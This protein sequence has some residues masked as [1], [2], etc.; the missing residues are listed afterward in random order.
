MRKSTEGHGYLS[1]RRLLAAMAAIAAGGVARITVPTLAFGAEQ[2][3]PA[4]AIETTD[5]AFFPV[6]GGLSGFYVRDDPRGPAFWSLFD[7]AG[8]HAWYGPPIS[9]VWQ[10]AD[11]WYQLFA[12]AMFVQPLTD[13][14][15]QLAPIVDLI[16]TGPAVSSSF[17]NAT[18][19]EFDGWPQYSQV[20][21]V[22]P[23]I[24]V[25]VTANPGLQPGVARSRPREFAGKVR[26]LFANLGLEHVNGQV[27]LGVLGQR[28]K[29]YFA[30]RPNRLPSAA[31]V[32]EAF[33]VS[34]EAS[35]ISDDLPGTVKGID[36]G[37]GCTLASEQ[38][39]G[40]GV[41]HMNRLGLWWNREQFIWS[42]ME[43]YSDAALPTIATD[44]NFRVSKEVVG[45]L[46][47]TPEYAGGGP[48][49]PA[50]FNPPRGLDLP[51]SDPSNLFGRFARG[52][53]ESRRPLDGAPATS[54]SGLNSISRW[55]PSNEPDICRPRMPGYAWGGEPHKR[56][57]DRT[58]GSGPA[59]ADEIDDAERERLLHR[60]VQVA[61]DAM[62][63]ADPEARLIFPSLGVLDRSCDNTPRQM[64]FWDGWVK[65]LAE[66][67]DRED[68]LAKNFWFHDMSLTLH[69][70]PERVYEMAAKYRAAL[71]GLSE[72]VGEPDPLAGRRRLIAMEMGLQ[73]DPG[74]GAYFDDTDVA[75]FIIQ[76]IA[77]ALV[78]GADEV[79]LHKLIDYPL[80]QSSGQGARVAVRYLSHV[81]RQ[82]PDRAK[83]PDIRGERA[84]NAYAGPVRIDLPGPGFVTSVFY[85]RKRE[86][87]D[88]TLSFSADDERSDSAIH[89][90]DHIGNE[91]T[92]SPGSHQL[93][94]AAPRQTFNAFGK[95][96]AWVA[97]GTHVVRY[98]NAVTLTT[99]PPIP[100]TVPYRTI[101]ATAN[102]RTAGPS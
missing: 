57:V 21:A 80:S 32:P 10:D 78:G 31:L 68:L 22:A 54:A 14:E 5:G 65:F 76:A 51:A 4:N 66:R 1:R 92:L 19:L 102:A 94:L 9:R 82:H 3:L 26:N 55:I 44:R 96:W 12:C 45:L 64:Q 37:F 52:V 67:T 17:S 56:W 89:L 50:K 93:T 69:K 7:A 20:T 25:F 77:N 46:Q 90:S 59:A 2:L 58:N 41:N 81:T 24:Q 38:G 30:G 91:Q 60:L 28:Y 95:N 40:A 6:D 47:F 48:S 13:G 101:P 83:Y 75:H 87:I 84:A 18:K 79:A 16:V 73:D 100:D 8:G 53:I 88:L 63:A 62:I 74:L 34:D 35:G 61:Y 42:A 72:T 33:A 71:D 85:N 99:D 97:G 98:S 49:E 27:R 86:P 70:E 29:S 39:V 43:A 36:R 15:P 23:A 11:N